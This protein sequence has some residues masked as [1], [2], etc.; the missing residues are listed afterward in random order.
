MIPQFIPWNLKFNKI[1]IK[2]ILEVFRMKKI[3]TRHT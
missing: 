3:I 1:R 2:N